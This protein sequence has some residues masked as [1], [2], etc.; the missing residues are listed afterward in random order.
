MPITRE[1]KDERISPTKSKSVERYTR[2]RYL[3]DLQNDIKYHKSLIT[4]YKLFA[5]KKPD[6][7]EPM[8]ASEELDLELTMNKIRRILNGH[9]D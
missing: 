4:K 5:R 1:S 9:K 3:D 6:V 2:N 8:I 7:W